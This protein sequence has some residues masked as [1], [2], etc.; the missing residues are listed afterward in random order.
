MQAP[1]SPPPHAAKTTPAALSQRGGALTAAAAELAEA[2][3]LTNARNLAHAETP[4]AR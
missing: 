4:T 1:T 3:H 2:Q